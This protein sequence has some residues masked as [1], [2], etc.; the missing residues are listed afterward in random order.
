MYTIED[1]SFEL[2]SQVEHELT[3]LHETLLLN[4]LELF[5]ISD[6]HAETISKCIL[7]D[8]SS[9][10]IINQVQGIKSAYDIFNDPAGFLRNNVPIIASKD[11]FTDIYVSMHSF[12]NTPTLL[13]CPIKSQNNL[14]GILI[15]HSSNI[16]VWDSEDVIKTIEVSVRIRKPIEKIIALEGLRMTEAKHRFILS[17]ARDA[18]LTYDPDGTVTYITGGIPKAYIGYDADEIIGKNF[19]DLIHPDYHRL[20][21]QYIEETKRGIVHEYHEYPIR[22][23]DSNYYW[24]RLHCQPIMNDEGELTG[25]VSVISYID[26]EMKYKINLELSEEKYRLLAEN[27]HDM[28]VTFDVNGMPQYISPSITKIIGFNPDEILQNVRSSGHFKLSQYLTK[29]SR[30]LVDSFVADKLTSLTPETLDPNDATI[31]DLDL[32]HKDGNIVKSEACVS[33]MVNPRTKD[34]NILTVTRKISDRKNV[35][36]NVAKENTAPIIGRKKSKI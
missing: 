4:K 28:I 10:R 13:I 24:F 12:D 32:I 17:N 2:F 3:K 1:F 34:I 33:F 6:F 11:I 36:V 26:K 30:R 8:T 9:S 25:F 15:C 27:M 29:E 35:Y 18:L 7:A 22:S 23:K 20:C 5:I 14:V 21:L 31:L 19:I 16:R